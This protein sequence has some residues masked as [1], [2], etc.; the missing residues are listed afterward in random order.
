MRKRLLQLI[1]E[2]S[3]REGEFKLASGKTSHFYVDMRKTALS[4]EGASLIG[5]VLID[6]FAAEGWNPDGA[7]G[8]TLGA[9]P[10]ATAVGIAS[11]RRGT[12]IASFIVRKQAKEHGAC[13]QVEAAGELRAGARVVV[14]DDTVTTGASTLRAIEAL[15]QAGYE[16]MGAACIVDRDEGG[17]ER[18]AN[19]GVH[20]ARVFAL[21]ELRSA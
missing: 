7:G 4:P 18:L 17:R 9:D 8:M 11:W 5:E 15:R 6:L 16:V 1:R 14:L 3:Y 12:P 13:R 10:L 2:H 21:T 19:A 20:L